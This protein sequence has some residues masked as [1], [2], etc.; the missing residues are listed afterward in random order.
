MENSSNHLKKKMYTMLFDSPLKKTY[1]IVLPV[2]LFSFFFAQA[3]TGPGGV[4]SNLG[5]WLRADMNTG[6]FVEDATVTTWSDMSVNNRNAIADNDPAFKDNIIGFMPAIE[7]DIDDSHRLNNVDINVRNSTMFGVGFSTNG[8]AFFWHSDQNEKD[9]ILGINFHNFVYVDGQ[10]F[11]SPGPRNNK[12]HPIMFRAQ[13]SNAEKYDV[14]FLSGDNKKYTIN[15][16]NDENSAVE[17]HY[18]TLGNW[19]SGGGLRNWDFISETIVLETAS[20]SAT[21]IQRIESYLAFKYGFT[22]EHSKNKDLIASDNT[23]KIW[24]A[25]TATGYNRL[26]F[27]IGRDDN[28][29]LHKKIGK[30]LGVSSDVIVSTNSDFTSSNRNTSRPDINTDKTFFVLAANSISFKSLKAKKINVSGSFYPSK[31]KFNIQKSAGFNQNINLKFSDFNSDWKLFHSTS[32]DFSSNIT[33]LGFLNADGEILNLNIDNGFIVLAKEINNT[34]T[35]APGGLIDNLGI[36]LKADVGTSTTTDGATVTT[37]KDQSIFSQTLSASSTPS[38]MESQINFNPT[39]FYELADRHIDNEPNLELP[40]TIHFSVAIP[41]GSHD[42]SLWTTSI[43]SDNPTYLTNSLIATWDDHTGSLQTSTVPWAENEVAL[44]SNNFDNVPNYPLNFRKNGAAEFTFSESKLTDLSKVKKY[45][46]LGNWSSGNFAFGHVAETI[47]MDNESFSNSDYSKVSSYL[48][49]KYGITLDQS[50]TNTGFEYLASN[51]AVIWSPDTADIFEHAIFGIGRDNDSGLDQKVSRSVNDSIL[52][53]A[54]TKDFEKS[55]QDNARQSLNNLQFLVLGNNNGAYE[56]DAIGTSNTTNTDSRLKRVWK[57]QNTGGVGNIHLEFTQLTD[58]EKYYLLEDIDTNFTSGATELTSGV[59]FNGKVQFEA[60]LSDNKTYTIAKKIYQEDDEPIGTAM[61]TPLSNNFMK[62]HG[63]FEIL[64]NHVLNTKENPSNNT[65]HS[66]NSD[67]NDRNVNND[68]VAMGYIDTDSDGTT[69]SSSSATLALPNCSRIAYA[70]LY[71]GG[72]YPFKKGHATDPE[73]IPADNSRDESYKQV[74]FKIPGGDYVDIGPNSDAKFEYRNIYDGGEADLLHRPYLNYANVTHLIKPL[75]SNL[76]GEYTV[77]NVVGSLDKKIDGSAA[78]WTLVLIYENAA[79][80]LK[81]VSTKDGFVEISGRSGAKFNFSDFKTLG[82]GSNVNIKMGIAAME[83]DAKTT[84]PQVRVRANS[85]DNWHIVSTALNPQDN[86]FNSTISINDSNIITRNPK[87]SNS[88]GWDMDVFNIPNPSNNVIPNNHSNLDVNVIRTDDGSDVSYLYLQVISTEIS[89]AVMQF[90]KTVED[91]AGNNKQDEEINMGDDFNYVLTLKNSGNVNAQNVVISTPIPKNTSFVSSDVTNATG[92]TV[93]ENNNTLQVSVPNNLVSANSNE[94]RIKLR[95]R[96]SDNCIDY[97]AACDHEIET[98]SMLSYTDGNGNTITNQPN[99]ILDPVCNIPEDKKIR[100]QIGNLSDCTF[101]KDIQLCGAEVTITAGSGFESYSWVKDT[102]DNKQVDASDLT[103]NDGDPDNNPATIKVK[104]TGIYIA[105]KTADGGCVDQVEIIKVSLFGVT[106]TNPIIAFLTEINE[107]DDLTNDVQWDE[108]QCPNDGELLPQISLCGSNDSQE[109][110][111]NINDAQSLVWE[112]LDD[113]NC[114]NTP[115]NCANK[116]PNCGWTQQATG[117]NFTVSSAGNYRLVLNY[118]NG[119]FSRFYFN[120]FQNNL[121][122]SFSKTDKSCN[123]NGSIQINNS[124][125]NYAFRLLNITNNTVAVPFSANNGSNFAIA[126]AGTYRVEF[127]QIDSNTNAP[128]EGGCIFSTPDIGILDQQLDISLSGVTGNCVQSSSITVESNL[129]NNNY[130]YKLHRD[131]GSGNAGELIDSQSAVTEPNFTFS[132]IGSGDFVVVATTN[133][134]CSDSNTISIASDGNPSVN[135]ALNDHISCID[136]SVT[137]TASGGNPNPSYLFAIWSKDGTDLFSEVSDIPANQIQTDATF[138]FAD[139]EDG[140]YEFVVIDSNNCSSVSNAVTVNDVGS[141][142]IDDP[143]LSNELDCNNTSTNMT[144]EVTGGTAPFQFSIDNGVTTQANA[145]FNNLSEGTYSVKVVDANDCEATKT[146]TLTQAPPIVFSAGITDDGTCSGSNQVTAEVI[147]IQGGKTPYTISYD[148]GVTFLAD[149]PANREIQL[150]PGN[151]TFI[152]RDDNGCT[153]SVD[154]IVPQARPTPGFDNTIVYNCEGKGTLTMKP[155]QNIYDYTYAID[156]TDNNPKSNPVFEDLAPGTYEI[157]TSFKVKSNLAAPIIFEDNFGNGNGVTNPNVPNYCWES[158]NNS[159]NDCDN[160][161][162]S[163]VNDGEYVVGSELTN[164]WPGW[165]DFSDNTNNGADSRFLFIAVEPSGDGLTLYKKE[166]NNLVP[167]QE[168]EASFALLNAMATSSNIGFDPNVRFELRI[169]GTTTVVDSFTSGAVPRNEEWNLFNFTLNPGTNSSLELVLVSVQTSGFG[170]DIAI[171][172][173]VIRQAP[174]SCAQNV[175]T[176]IT[177]ESGKEFAAEIEH[178]EN[179]SCNGLSD[180]SV[181]IRTSNATASEG[182]QWSI[183]NGNNWTT[184]TDNPFTIDT[185]SEGTN[186]IQIRKNDEPN[187]SL[188]LSQDI[189]EPDPVSITASIGRVVTCLLPQGRVAFSATGGIAPYTFSLENDSG[190]VLENFASN[191]DGFYDNLAPGTYVVAVKDANECTVVKSGEITLNPVP[192]I[193]HTATPTPCYAGDSNGTIAVSSS[194]AIAPLQFSIDGGIW[195]DGE[196]NDSHTFGNLNAGTYSIKIKDAAGCEST[197]TNVVIQEQL[198]ATAATTHVSICAPGSISIT[199]SGGSGSLQYAIVE[200]NTD[201]TGSFGTTSTL[202]INQATAISNT[203]WDAYIRDN[204]NAAP[205]CQ[206][207]LEDITVNPAIQWDIENEITNPSCNGGKGSIMVELQNNGTKLTDTE[208]LQAGPF[209]YEVLLEGTN[210]VIKSESNLSLSE[211]IFANLSPNTYDVRV[212]DT[213]N[214]QQ[215]KTVEIVN[216]PELSADMVTLFPTPDPNNPS[217]CDLADRVQFTNYPEAN[218]IDGDLQFSINNG[219]N[220]FNNDTFTGKTSG[221]E[222]QPAMRIV[223][224]AGNVTKII[225]FNILDPYILNFPLDD[226]GITVSAV[227]SDCTKLTVDVL[228]TKGNP[229]Y[230]Y[231][232]T[233]NPADW[234]ENSAIWTAVTPSGTT[235]TFENQDSDTPQQAGLPILIPGRTYAFYVR[236]SHGCIRQSSKNVNNLVNNPIEF[237][238]DIKNSCYF[239]APDTANGEIEFSLNPAAT[240]TMSGGDTFSWELRELGTNTLIDSGTDNSIPNSI[241]VDELGPEGNINPALNTDPKKYYLVARID[242]SSGDLKC[243][244]GTEN[245]KVNT[246][247]ALSGTVTESRA[248]GCVQPG[249]IDAT[250]IAGGNGTYKFTVTRP[251]IVG[252]AGHP[253]TITIANEVSQE[254]IEIP[255]G[256]PAGNYTVVVMDEDACSVNLTVAMS[257][258]PNPSIDDIE[259]DNCSNSIQVKVTASPNPS[260]LRYAMVSAGNPAPTSFETNGGIFENVAAGNYD[261]YVINNSGC[262]AKETSVRVHPPLLASAVLSKPIDCSASPSAT[263]DIEITQGSGDYDYQVIK[264]VGSAE[265]AVNKQSVPSNSFSHTAPTAG[266]Y[267]ITIFVD[268]TSDTKACTRVFDIVVPEQKTPQFDLQPTTV[269]CN[270]GDNGK[271]SI[272]ETDN[273]ISPLTYQLL[274]SSNNPVAA[275]DF[276]F[277]NNTKTFSDL[278]AG[279]YIVRATGTNECTRDI[280]IDIEEPDAI[281]IPALDVVQFG[282]TSSNDKNNASIAI[283]VSQLTGGSG[284]YPR[285]VFKDPSNVVVQDGTNP[286][287]VIDQNAGGTY[288]IEVHDS[289]GCLE[290]TTQNINTFDVLESVNITVDQL[291]DCTNTG[292][293]I[294]L[295]AN[296]SESNSTDPSHNY[297]FKLTSNNTTNTTGVFSNL[298]VGTY[299]FEITNTDTG[300]KLLKTHTV[301]DLDNFN[302]EVKVDTPVICFG[303]DASVHIEV[304]NYTGAFSFDIKSNGSSVQTGTGTNGT[305]NAISLPAGSYVLDFEQTAHPLCSRTLNFTIPGPLAALDATVTE[306]GNASCNN[307]QGQLEVKP[308]GGKAPYSIS[309]DTETAQNVTSFVFENLSD[310]VHNVSVTDALGC[311]ATFSGSVTRIEPLVANATAAANPLECLGDNNGSITANIS[312]GGTGEINFTLL[313][314]DENGTVLQTGIPQDNATF[315]DL[316]QG[317]YAILIKDDANCEFTTNTIN[318][319][320]PTP[321]VPILVLKNPLECVQKAEIELRVSGGTP[322][323]YQ[324]SETKNGTYQ[325]FSNNTSHTFSNLE[326]GTYQFWVK[327]I[328]NCIPVKTN[329]IT[330]SPIQDIAILVDESK[331]IVYCNGDDNA[332]IV[333]TATGGVGNYQYQLFDDNGFTSQAAPPNTTGIFNNL[334][335]G[336]YFVRVESGDC[337]A[338]FTGSIEI[339]EPTAITFLGSKTNIS[340][341]GA[342]DGTITV[343]ATGGAGNYQFAISPNLNQFKNENTFTNL[344]AGNYTVVAQDGNGCFEKLTFEL[345]QPEALVVNEQIRHEICKDANDGSIQ[346]ELSGAQPPYRTAINSTSDSDFVEGRTKFENLAPG[347]YKI[348]IRDAG[349]CDVTLDYEIKAGKNILAEVNTI[350]TCSG[351]TPA[352]HLEIK[353][354]DESVAADVMYSLDSKE[355]SNYV[356]KPNYKNLSPGQ[357]VLSILHSNGC[358]NEISFEVQEYL[359]VSV[360][361]ENK[362]VNVITVNASGGNQ[363]YTYYLNGEKE[364][365]QNTFAIFKS[366]TYEVTVVDGRGC[367]NTASITVEFLDIELP[368]FF[369]PN[370]DGKNDRWKPGYINNYP[371]ASIIVYDRYGRELYKISRDTEGWDGNYSNTSLPAGDYWFIIRL[372]HEEDDREFIGH[373]TLIR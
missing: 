334:G 140:V 147:G 180:G 26:V 214:C 50:G 346:L 52:T 370:N 372:N 348:Y 130:T 338:N 264:T 118:Q 109:I 265:A 240:T 351:N 126:N 57:A 107:D 35:T 191:T 95:M 286:K 102:N 183:D 358:E 38:F 61:G 62:I 45:H 19:H 237:D 134:G 161:G 293:S 171:D 44:I 29:G 199:A 193:T 132:D 221:D 352:N 184:T 223:D 350:Y 296:G 194:D 281:S 81:Y 329:A 176:T 238:L 327:D 3:Q 90:E 40:G 222:I 198:V 261:I 115:A 188:S 138:T 4:T 73:G 308:S 151:Y 128:L 182:V 145:T 163:I 235:H 159:V 310:G 96:L 300:C 366:G 320:D 256:S 262:I 354:E 141:P 242:D 49:I 20:P 14:N 173:I 368:S 156:G 121:N 5:L 305:T 24:N 326:A 100:F 304:S 311:T 170:N 86:F 47:I 349:N 201:P 80:S 224:D 272:V 206:V 154:V 60:T 92:T 226:L 137:L 267:Q 361:L 36:W 312:S 364:S 17:L 335:A 70:G 210:T 110:N 63:D 336:T 98:Q 105:T 9:V 54:T 278:S 15:N 13:Y 124:E 31:A 162:N 306:R 125:N 192:V 101:E 213:N 203:K 243:W 229:P 217:D 97:T 371:N 120:A 251:S 323:G 7:Y 165:W 367:T 204:S 319:E 322:G 360:Q 10:S 148:N 257:T 307:N 76:N 2:L 43:E 87:N 89:S 292:E 233:D 254:I 266:T 189:S 250:D 139:G 355:I 259:I 232:Y 316:N 212:T 144:I 202:S 91:L 177:I 85:S 84:G 27:G 220:W 230:Q 16:A 332:Q 117:N 108:V 112:K 268:A 46:I 324:W 297:S 32:E 187:C 175:N 298:D 209:R 114:G 373:F 150:D 277:S 301:P 186:N 314:L 290:S 94:I 65:S 37:W 82:A 269:S 64:S 142:E 321:L 196:N 289:N 71:W 276:S 303:S 342:D 67:F 270:G 241:T 249:L 75:D 331:A 28:S 239:R 200:A 253:T 227:V 131:D 228:G 174:N 168:L 179:I 41:K 66:P 340:C 295:V 245:T 33:D 280:S 143:T 325:A 167:N 215:I 55:N 231:T 330:E 178:F 136:G 363:N 343:E 72:T 99:K 185:L 219:Q 246:F 347:N 359:P 88:F 34:I 252:E 166:L 294:T 122:V 302:I 30:G 123:N 135:A 357:H 172:D 299:Q 356:L 365:R 11:K 244:S 21:D 18:W 83:G 68:E 56:F 157:T 158:Q 317:N 247:A 78:G 129:G 287:L 12:D 42:H 181:R 8:R 22:L 271:I 127:T 111:L 113:T 345:T 53:I 190:A 155:D 77:A 25:S 283:D 318:L 146:I 274:D 258:L 225:C 313:R 216:P 106:K 51:D 197:A 104:E 207:L 59:A 337:S 195:I 273:G 48:A 333:V 79:E 133:S 103:I 160:G 23:T 119:C 152:A 236:D 234:E 353:L 164:P 328:N 344:A 149:T 58:G 6:T 291:R 315:N 69:F 116:D 275:G 285:F 205:F 208:V 279:T 284:N 263:I 39:V 255:V 362:E 339:E 211:N 341:N 74:K 369:T 1:H 288:T 169:P 153:Q 248:I 93:T 218:D 309:L 282:C 260:V